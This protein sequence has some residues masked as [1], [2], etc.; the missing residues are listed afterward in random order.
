MLSI[1]C[2]VLSMG[3]RPGELDRALRSLLAQ[4]DV[5]L[6]IVVVGN[7][8]Q[9]SDLPAGVR[10]VGLADNVGVPEGR[11][12]GAREVRGD[13]LHFF[14]DDA[15]WPDLTAL[16]AI[17]HRFEVDPDLGVLQ[18]RAVDPDGG[19]TARRHIPRLRVAG[20]ERPGDVGWFWEGCS[21]VRRTCFEQC[22]GWPGQFFYGHES[23]ELSWRAIDRGWR[24]HYA[25]DIAVHNPEAEAF[26]GADRAFTNARNRVWVARRNLPHGWRE[27]YLVVWSLITLARVRSAASAVTG[28]RGFA[29]GWRE[30]PGP[31]RRRLSRVGAW[32]LTRVGRPPII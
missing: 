1:G 24:V 27:A 22:G 31:D 11:N 32:R 3:T 26:A 6:D 21:F 19:A 8:W 18:P 16:A 7:G 10:S 20:A 25:A 4:R 29:A 2:V 15:E 17:A 28:V 5:D 12:V 13:V 9:P 30:D 14:D 23:I